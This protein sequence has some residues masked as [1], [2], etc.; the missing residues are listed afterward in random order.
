MP[1]THVVEF[2]EILTAAAFLLTVVAPRLQ[3]VRPSFG[4]VT[5]SVAL[6][7]GFIGLLMLSSIGQI[8]LL[9][10]PRH[11][12]ALIYQAVMLLAT[13]V[14]LFVAIRRR[15]VEAVYIAAAALTMFLFIRYIDWFWDALPRF[16]FFLVLATVA[17]AW[18]LTLRRLRARVT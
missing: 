16:V 1:W 4:A 14:T 9:P 15:W 2:P 10:T 18:L 8:S 11:V 6:G 5:R 13:V 3:Q 17:F 12:S 7:V